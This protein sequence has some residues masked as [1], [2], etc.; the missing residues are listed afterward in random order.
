MR[1]TVAYHLSLWNHLKHFV[2]KMALR[3][4]QKPPQASK[5]ASDID[6]DSR[7]LKLPAELRNAIYTLA[8]S[9]D[10]D[11]MVSTVHKL[12]RPALL[13]TCK[14]IRAEATLL[15]FSSTTFHL[16]ISPTEL[17]F[18]KTWLRS[19]GRESAAAINPLLLTLNLDQANHR[20][21][22]SREGLEWL[23][24]YRR[25]WEDLA[26]AMLEAGI[27]S[28]AVIQQSAQYLC[29]GEVLDR[30]PCDRLY[31]SWMLTFAEDMGVVV[32]RA[33]VDTGV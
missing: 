14:Q 25:K 26:K 29:R 1:Y 7:L 3:P 9:F 8:L 13:K 20:F 23:S 16:V 30:V 27:R 12:R 32:R 31:P 6:Q 18:T 15:Y 5:I 33:E 2:L 22:R 10:E 24:T 17:K 11:I 4:S 19:I 21:C 28:E